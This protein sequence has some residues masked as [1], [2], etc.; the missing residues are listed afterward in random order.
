MDSVESDLALGYAHSLRE[1]EAAMKRAKETDE[2]DAVPGGYRRL[3]DAI[4]QMRLGMF[5]TLCR[6][7]PLQDPKLE[8]RAVYGPWKETAAELVVKAA[9]AGKLPIY[10]FGNPKAH[11]SMGKVRQR[12]QYGSVIFYDHTPE[13]EVLPV[14]VAVLQRMITA[15]GAL[16]DRHRVSLKAAGGNPILFNALNYGIL[17]VKDEDFRA[18]YEKE[19]DKG[20]WPSQATKLV[21]VGRPSKQSE[22]LKN[23]VAAILATAPGTNVAD[24]HRQLLK[25]G[26]SEVPSVDTIGRLVRKLGLETGDPKYRRLQKTRR[27]WSILR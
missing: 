3:S 4:G 16:P 19:R 23:A 5:A 9:R 10:V 26:F 8:V 22:R 21:K 17:V 1:A 14:P 18:W 27:R 7:H 2:H 6:P 15:R 20:R 12:D 13:S 24:I 11:E 25:Q